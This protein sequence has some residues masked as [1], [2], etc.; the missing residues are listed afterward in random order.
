MPRRLFSPPDS[1]LFIMSSFALRFV[2]KHVAL[3]ALTPAMLSTSSCG[4]SEITD[5]TEQIKRE[6]KLVASKIDGLSKEQQMIIYE[7]TDLSRQTASVPWLAMQIASLEKSLIQEQ[8]LIKEQQ[9]KISVAE[10][11]LEKYKPMMSKPTPPAF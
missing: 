7:T 11:Y 4:L 9:K 3:A 2:S 5:R 6:A 10:N 8:K 1:F